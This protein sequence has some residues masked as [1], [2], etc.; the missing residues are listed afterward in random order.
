MILLDQSDRLGLSIASDPI[1]NL[2]SVFL[3]QLLFIELL[4]DFSSAE[5]LAGVVFCSHNLSEIRILHSFGSKSC[6]IISSRNILNIH[7]PMR[8]IKMGV[9][10]LKR[11]CMIVHL[12]KEIFHEVWMVVELMAP[13]FNHFFFSITLLFKK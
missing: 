13:Y 11:S 5:R 10:H 2:N 3:A 6:H 4:T 8:T 9:R 12:L 7:Q 1:I